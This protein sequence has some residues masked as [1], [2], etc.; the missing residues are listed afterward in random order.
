MTQTKNGLA[1]EIYGVDF[2]DLTPGQKAAV[3]REYNSQDEDDYDEPEDV[4]VETIVVKAGR[5]GNGPLKEFA[6]DSDTTVGELLAKAG[7]EIDT[8]KESIL[9]QSEGVK[10]SKDDLVEDGETYILTPEIKSA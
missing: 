10:V 2:A 8:K 9:A 1:N 5:V 3:S 7:L 6:M 4:A